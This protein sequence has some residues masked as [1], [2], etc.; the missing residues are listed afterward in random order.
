MRQPK[1]QEPPQQSEYPTQACSRAT[2]LLNSM[3]VDVKYKRV[4][5]KEFNAAYTAIRQLN[6]PVHCT[7]TQT[8]GKRVLRCSCYRP[9]SGIGESRQRKRRKR[10]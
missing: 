7:Q 3:A 1:Y 9:L 10:G 8:A 4:T 5:M 6:I 2:W